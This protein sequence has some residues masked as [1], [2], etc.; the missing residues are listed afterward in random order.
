MMSGTNDNKGI[1]K[2][3]TFSL[4]NEEIKQK[5]EEIASWHNSYDVYIWLW[6]EVEVKLATAYK[7]DVTEHGIEV[8][9]D[10]TRVML[11]PP[12]RK[13][14]ELATQMSAGR[15]KLQDVH[16]FSAESQLILE[17][18]KKVLR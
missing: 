8:K 15:P 11:E 7:I 16:W 5:A 1:P 2:E 3:L 12:E 18:V 13:I 10:P 9:V 17:R 14:M 6:A 4:S